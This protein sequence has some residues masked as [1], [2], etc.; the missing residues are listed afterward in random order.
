VR[1]TGHYEGVPGRH[2]GPQTS[3]DA[4][5]RLSKTYRAEVVKAAKACFPCTPYGILMWLVEKHRDD[6]FAFYQDPIT[7][8]LNTLQN[9]GMVVITGRLEKN[10]TGK[11]AHVLDFATP[12]QSDFIKKITGGG[13]KGNFAS[14]DTLMDELAANP[15]FLDLMDDTERIPSKTWNL[16]RKWQ[17]GRPY[18]TVYK[19]KGITWFMENYNSNGKRKSRNGRGT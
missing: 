11:N 14:G 19:D 4:A 16:F 12:E 3:R 6:K 1:S 7:G 15:H 8:V 18:K 2:A 9:E 10:P 13:A 17:R 5:K